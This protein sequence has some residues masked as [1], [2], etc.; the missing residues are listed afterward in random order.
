MSQQPQ[1]R[2]Q[3]TPK[4]EQELLNINSDSPTLATIST[5]TK[6]GKPRTATFPIRYMKPYTTEKVTELLVGNQVEITDE[7][8]EFEALDAVK[9]KSN[10]VHQG[11]AYIIL[12]SFWKIKL[13]H[14][15]LWRWF[16][17]VKEYNY[18]DLMEIVETGKKKIQ[19]I[20]FLTA[21]ASLETMKETKMMMTRKEAKPFLQE[22]FKE[23]GQASERKTDGL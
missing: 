21:M 12:N 7:M 8:T 17:Y 3:P 23:Y 16:Y 15:I 6:K 19:L 14:G 4:D 9:D 11:A 1:S 18:L 20:P 10:A 22:L 2:K 5:V 13:F